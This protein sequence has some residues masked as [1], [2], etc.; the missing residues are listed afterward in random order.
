MLQQSGM[1]ILAG[2]DAG[3]LNSFDYPGIGLHDEL[4]L[5][6]RYGLTPLQALQAATINGARFLGHDDRFGTLAVGKSADM[7][8]LRANPVED[9][10]ATRRIDTVVLRGR[11]FDRGRLDMMLADVRARVAAE[12]AARDAARKPAKNT[13]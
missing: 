12:N 3:F 10:A 1:T 5:L 9:I 7:V 8:L 13:P 11:A 2:T 6:V 4:G